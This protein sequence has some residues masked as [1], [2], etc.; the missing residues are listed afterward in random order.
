[1]LF[2][3]RYAMLDDVVGFGLVPWR[4]VIDLSVAGHAVAGLV[5]GRRPDCRDGGAG[6]LGS[7]FFPGLVYAEDI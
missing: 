2:S 5:L 6:D 7:I 1:M 4:P 3:G